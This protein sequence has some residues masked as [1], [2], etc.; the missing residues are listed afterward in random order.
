[1]QQL[2]PGFSS[3]SRSRFAL[4]LVAFTFFLLPLAAKAAQ[5]SLRLVARYAVSGE[6][7]APTDVRWAGA[8]SAYLVRYEDGVAEVKLSP[9][10]PVIRTLIPSRTVGHLA[11]HFM[12]VAAANGT[13]VYADHD[14]D[15]GWRPI[16]TPSDLKVLYKRKKIGVT[17]GMDLRGDRLLLIGGLFDEELS[18]KY[19][20]AGGIAGFGR[21]ASDFR[22]LKPLV[23]D[24]EGRYAP[25]LDRCRILDA[26]GARFLLDGSMFVV[27]A[28]V[29]GAFLYDTE[30]AL[31]RSWSNADLGVDDLCAGVTKDLTHVFFGKGSARQAWRNSRRVIDAVLPLAQGPAVIVRSV[32]A[33]RP[34]WQLKVLGSRGI[35]TYAIP[36]PDAGPNDR[37]IADSRDARIVLLRREENLSFDH[38]S[39]PGELLVMELP[40]R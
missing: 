38:Q 39:S 3:R 16:Q 30:G 6:P 4:W 1:M 27:P 17:M 11:K 33:G 23:L 31:K 40:T 32:V 7:S 25:H 9:G 13:L 20:E 15:I 28:V 36:V 5:P 22:D 34:T 24:S 10:L 19:D 37:L 12:L 14:W 2:P 21:L 8:D 18:G 35:A 26:G 29:P